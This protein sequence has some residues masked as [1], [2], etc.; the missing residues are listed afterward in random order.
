M[1]TLTKT[2]SSS[3]AAILFMAEEN[4][5]LF[6]EVVSAAYLA[7]GVVGCGGRIGR[8]NRRKRRQ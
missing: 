7:V 6:S 2:L 4:E 3:L 1:W 8:E 5:L